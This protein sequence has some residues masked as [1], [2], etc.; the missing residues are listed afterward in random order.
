[1]QANR[2][3]SE[4]LL[5]SL[6]VFHVCL[7]ISIDPVFSMDGC[8]GY[9]VCRHT[10]GLANGRDSIDKSKNRYFFASWDLHRDEPCME[11]AGIQ[12][13]EFVPTHGNL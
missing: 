13:C 8:S 3:I 10:C 6:D 1:M 12:L 2:L 4:N 5:D 11:A 7:K 9:I